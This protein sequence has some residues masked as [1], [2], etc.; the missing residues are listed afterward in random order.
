MRKISIL[1]ISLLAFSATAFIACS[2]DDLGPS[3]FDTKEK[4]LDRTV[5]TFPLDTF[6]KANFLEPYNLKFIYKLPDI[7]SDLQ[8]N[9]IPASYEN[10]VKLAVLCKYLWYDVYLKHAG[11]DF[12][13]SYSPRILL[14][15]GSPSVNASSHTETLG[16]AE[17][18]L[19]IYLYKVNTL[20]ENDVDHLNY[21]FFHTMHHEFAHI[22]DQT[23]SRPQAFNLLS[24]G[25]YDPQSWGEQHDSVSVGKGF[26]TPYASSAAR[27]DWVEVM[28]S[29]ITNDEKEWAR[30][31]GAAAYEWESIDLVNVDSINRLLARGGDPDTIGYVQVI[32]SNSIKLVRKVIARNANGYAALKDGKPEFLDK[33]GFNGQTVI[34]EK[35]EM[36][37]EWLQKEFNTNLEDLRREVQSRTFLTNPDGSFVKKDGQFVNRL[38]SPLPSNPQQTLIDSL[39]NEVNKFKGLIIKK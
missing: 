15:T 1:L 36:V 27:E 39:V 10:S 24:N 26:I 22:L 31:I 33:D 17:G 6:V 30:K 2:D 37:R 38:V 19:K 21:Y 32:S 35:L 20:N 13:K 12:L 23:H 3:I 11:I 4:P 25:K 14:L 8:K 16:T 28:S 34:L 9:L 7:S 5:F 29:Y 18:G